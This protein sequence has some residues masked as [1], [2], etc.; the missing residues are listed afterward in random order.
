MKGEKMGE[1]KRVITKWLYWFVFAVAVI[2]VYKTV[3]NLGEILNWFGKLFSILMPFVIGI[4]IAYLFY[5]P[6]KNWKKYIQRQ[7]QIYKK[8]I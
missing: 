8:K 1:N 2:L 4:L 3:D 5:M 6:T 7:K